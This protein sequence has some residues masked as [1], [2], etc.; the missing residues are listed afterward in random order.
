MVSEAVDHDDVDRALFLADELQLWVLVIDKGMGQ[1]DVDW[2][3]HMA[4][5]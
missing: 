2:A 1:G 3:G 5:H 4:A